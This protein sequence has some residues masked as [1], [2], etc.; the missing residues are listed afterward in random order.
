MVYHVAQFPASFMV[1]VM[2]RMMIGMLIAGADGRA[3]A[4][5]VRQWRSGADPLFVATLGEVPARLADVV[6]NGDVVITQGAGDVGRLA[7]A[8]KGGGA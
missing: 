3:L 4:R 2:R 6:R 7:A 5:S 8:L 1:V